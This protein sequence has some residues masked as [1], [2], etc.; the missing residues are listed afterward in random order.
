MSFRR[1]MA[2]HMRTTLRKTDH[3][4]HRGD[5]MPQGQ[6]NDAQETFPIT[7]TVGDVSDQVTDLTDGRGQQSNITATTSLKEITDLIGTRLEEER[8]PLNGDEWTLTDGAYMG[9][10]SVVNVQPDEGD[11]VVLTLKYER[12]LSLGGNGKA[13]G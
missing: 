7:M 8:R 10:W 3:F 1:L 6:P 2:S 4:A 12:A 5:Y 13:G 11:G 9:T